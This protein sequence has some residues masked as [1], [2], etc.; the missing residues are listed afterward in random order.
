VSRLTQRVDVASSACS[1]ATPR[2]DQ[3]RRAGRQGADDGDPVGMMMIL[4][5]S[6]MSGAPQLLNSVIEEK[7]SR[8]SEVLI[9]S[10]TPFELM[11]GKLLGSVAVSLLLAVDL[12]GR[13]HGRG[14]A[15]RLRRRITSP[16]S[17][18]LC[19]F[20]LDGVVHVRLDLHHHRR[21]LLGSEGRAGHDDAGD[22]PA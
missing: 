16:T 15:L 2:G 22:A 3:G 14:A 4:L 17:A 12:H 11:M 21:R 8:I 19:V 9:G 18:W 6:V 5:F 7:M 13:R 1:S 20:L 10:I